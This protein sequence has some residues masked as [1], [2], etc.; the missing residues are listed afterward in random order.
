[1]KATSKAVDPKTLPAPERVDLLVNEV[2]NLQAR[3][4]IS[5]VPVIKYEETGTRP[6][7]AFR[8]LLTTENNG[9]SN[10]QEESLEAPTAKE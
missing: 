4:G 7:F 9:N 3:F 1:M 5:I 6:D 10:S 8:N 2:R